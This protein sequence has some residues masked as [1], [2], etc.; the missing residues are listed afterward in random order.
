MVIL[1]VIYIVALTIAAVLSFGRWCWELHQMTAVCW[2]LRLTFAY[3]FS[4]AGPAFFSLGQHS[5][6]YFSQVDKNVCPVDLLPVP[7]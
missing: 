6:L 2:A 4:V 1:R 5:I 7:L 3:S